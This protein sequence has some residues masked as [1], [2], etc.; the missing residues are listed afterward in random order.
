MRRWEVIVVAAL[1]LCG[2]R[3]PATA[4]PPGAPPVNYVPPLNPSPPVPRVPELA[5]IYTR[6]SVFAIPFTIDPPQSPT[7]RPVAVQLH[8]SEDGGVNWRVYEQVDP[9]ASKFTFRAAHDGDYQ[10]MVRTL[11]ASGRT[12][13]EG[14]AKAELRVVVD[15]LAPRL[16]LFARQSPTGEVTVSWRMLDR[17]PRPDTF[18]L[19]FQ[20]Q[21]S[22][23]WQ[24][25]TMPA[26]SDQHIDTGEVTF[27]PGATTGPIVI[28]AQ[29]TD[30]AGNPSVAQTELDLRASGEAE[31]YTTARRQNNSAHPAPQSNSW[32]SIDDQP[33]TG[34]IRWGANQ[35]PAP[36]IARREQ[37]AEEVLPPPTMEPV[38]PQPYGPSQTTRLPRAE[39]IPVGTGAMSAQQADSASPAMPEEIAPPS[40]EAVAPSRPPSP[41][42]HGLTSASSVPDERVPGEALPPETEPDDEPLGPTLGSD[43]T[44]PDY[45]PRAPRGGQFGFDRLP[46][47]ERPRVVNSRKFEID[48]EVE[49]VGTLGIAKIELW[50]TRD[51]GQTWT[52]FGYD[53]DNRS[54]FTVVVDQEGMY[55]FR[56]VIEAANGLGGLPPR[57]GD[58]PDVWVA[59]DLTKPV[60][61]LLGVEELREGGL[62]ALRIQWEA[63]DALLAANPISIAYSDQ[64]GGPWTSIIEGIDNSGEYVWRID[65]RLPD[66][67][68]LQVQARDEAGNVGFGERRDPV[69]LERLRP[70][71]RI[72]EVRPARDAKRGTTWTILR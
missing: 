49:S 19:E 54:P 48:Y 25:V 26:P 55:G 65:R 47:G 41:V 10:F 53:K 2:I 59:V 3:A 60:V 22:T 43:W 17:N 70:Q 45:A 28:R 36:P 29:V 31:V 30:Q 15:T 23:R 11:D 20:P 68:Y 7:G 12:Q 42:R 9:S 5:P 69:S 38:R 46:P 34:G 33:S 66:Q 27:W 8:V 24:A 50:G 18:R 62:G 58:K 64:P 16:E 4:Q 40:A 21:G 14:P 52:S 32:Q 13:P 44:E 61:R 39:H 51:W 71:G 72:R 6:Q 57:G 67:I 63:D 35:A 56:M 37:T 1:A